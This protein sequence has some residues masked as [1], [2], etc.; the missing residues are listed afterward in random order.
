M[1]R[2]YQG[3][4]LC[5]VMVPIEVETGGMLC[6]V[7]TRQIEAACREALPEGC[8]FRGLYSD[9]WIGDAEWSDDGEDDDE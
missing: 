8:E 9:D 5:L 4:L 6:S 3:R 7:T 1:K 2:K